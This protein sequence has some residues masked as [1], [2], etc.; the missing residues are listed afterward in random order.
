[1]AERWDIIDVDFGVPE[2]HEQGGARPCLIVYLRFE[3]ND[4]DGVSLFPPVNFDLMVD[5]PKDLP[6]GW[7]VAA[8]ACVQLTGILIPR[9]GR[10]SI[11]M[12]VEGNHM[13]SLPFQ[14]LPLRP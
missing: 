7:D 11:E 6:A 5:V 9:P 12:L 13:K 2:G 10:Y 8:A 4:Q 3:L 1:M 14:F